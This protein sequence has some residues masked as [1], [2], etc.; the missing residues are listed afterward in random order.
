MGG[1][2]SKDGHGS[3]GLVKRE[4]ELDHGVHVP[5]F[6]RIQRKKGNRG[7]IQ[8]GVK[9]RGK[10]FLDISIEVTGWSADLDSAR[11]QWGERGL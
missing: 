10:S 7:G 2:S 4:R 6:K 9:N 3:L 11:Y 8:G 1:I 5:D